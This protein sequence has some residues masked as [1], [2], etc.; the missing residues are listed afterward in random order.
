MSRR[1]GLRIDVDTLR[2]TQLGVPSLLKALDKAGVQASFFFSVGP[3]NMGRHLW[4][5]LRPK[6]LWKMWRSKAASLYGWQ[7]LL[8]GTLWPGREIA[9]HC[10]QEILAVKAAG[11]EIG[12]HA[13][14]HH[15][16]Q[17]FAS[18]WNEE[19]QYQ[20]QTRALVALQSIVGDD[21]TCSAVAG[22]RADGTTLAAKE[23]LGF[24]YNSDCRGTAPF[25]PRL[26]NGKLGTPQIP[27]TLPTYDEVV[28][29]TL[30]ASAFNAFILEQMQDALKQPDA[31]P[32]YT[33]HAEVE[34]MSQAALFGELLTL[35]QQAGITFCP[36]G[37]MLPEEI[38]TLPTASVE[39]APLAGREGWVGQQRP[40][41]PGETDA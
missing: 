28:G 29:P 19:Q 18:N 7:I 41:I 34:G 11:H 35:C 24:V 32:V 2:G 4:R 8:A 22:W 40:I 16:W 1:I 37:K 10:R 27:V 15:R 38:T 3:D 5:L 20:E 33:I 31:Q 39:R 25:L 21:V 36:L 23:A 30:S 9:R 14:D 17:A 26:P 6:F 12:L 13:W